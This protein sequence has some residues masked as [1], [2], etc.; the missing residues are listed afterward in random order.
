MS[1]SPDR[2]KGVLATV[3]VLAVAILPLRGDTFVVA[4]SGGDFTSIQAAVDAASAGDRV[5]VRCGTYLENVT[6][7]DGVHLRGVNPRCAIVDAS[8]DGDVI[9]IPEVTRPTIVEGLTIR[10]GSQHIGSFGAG[11]A[12]GAGSPLITRNIIEQNGIGGSGM[13][14]VVNGAWTAY[15]S[16]VITR[17]V[18][19]DNHNCCWGGG[20]SLSGTA[21]AQIT[22]NLIAGNSAYYGGG[23]Y[24]YVGATISGNTIVHNEAWLGGGVASFGGSITLLDNLIEGNSAVI[25]GGGV[26]TNDISVVSHNN[27]INNAPENWSTPVGD[28]TGIDGNVSVPS[29][30]VDPDRWTFEG[31]QPRS[32]SPLVDAGVQAVSTFDLRGVPRPLDG[33][34][35]GE[36]R[37]DI[38]ARENEGV[39]GVRFLR[40]DVLSWDTNGATF[41]QYR[42]D[43]A[44]LRATGIVTQDPAEFDGA[45]V[46]C[47]NA[48]PGFVQTEDPDPGRGFFYVIA[49]RGIELEGPLGV[50]SDGTLRTQRLVDCL[51]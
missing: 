24:S 13:G 41:D 40:G 29:E 45:E 25:Y 43:L 39:T 26:M 20:V 30:L 3:L 44:T 34:A 51:F 17:N 4:P 8:F 38:G 1:I 12:V 9:T 18:I 33:D 48:Q 37:S 14:I 7:K 5:E 31:V 28:L 11:V 16:P 2:A 23:I 10:N 47:L 15:D 21:D 42:G 32:T 46:I 6:M 27:V 22:G 50:S 36:A 19:R 49:V 35:D